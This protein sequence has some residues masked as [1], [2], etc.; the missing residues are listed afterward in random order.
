MKQHWL[1]STEVFDEYERRFAKARIEKKLSR[2]WETKDR[3]EIIASTKRMLRYDEALVPQ[4]SEMNEISRTEYQG[5]CAIQYRFQ[6]WKNMYGSATLYLP[7]SEEK[8][9]LVF[10][11]CGHG[12]QGR[13]SFGYMAMG[14]RLASLGIAALVMDNIGQGDRNLTPDQFKGPDHWMAVAPFHCGLTLQGLIVMETIGMIRYMKQDPRFDTDRFGACGNSGGGTLTMFLSALCPE[15]NVIASCGYPSEATYI[16][17]KER[18]HCACN[19]LIG[20]AYEAEMWEIYSVFA[21]KPLMLESGSFDNLIPPDLAHRNARKVMNTYVQ[22]DAMDNLV[23][24]LTNTK[25]PWELE[26][27]NLI[28]GFLS[29]KLLGVTPENAEEAFATEDLTPFRVSMPENMLTTSELSQKLTG[30]ELPDELELKDVF[31][32]TFNGEAIDP[33]SLQSDIGRGDVMR[34]FAQFECVLC[35]PDKKES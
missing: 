34:V 27:L 23:F 9:P 12:K 5:F 13:L 17:Q 32:P 3:E 4:I 18:R 8:V 26:D 19:L 7:H 2:P 20:Q 6:S 25:H 33:C 31:T 30:V 16:L 24:R 28:S 11:C 10:I 15:L 29:E 1:N 21:P 14:H 35:K 22:L